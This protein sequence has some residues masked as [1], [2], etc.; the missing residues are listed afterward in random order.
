MSMHTSR[1]GAQLPYRPLAGVVPCP[2]GWLVAGAKLQGIT[3]S[4]EAPQVFRTLLDILDYKPAYQII[5]LAAPIGLLDE[6]VAGGRHCDRDARRLIGWPR[7]GAI[8][9]PPA[10]SVLREL[11]EGVDVSLSAVGRRLVA[12]FAEVDE[13]IQP[14]WQRTVFEV[15]PELSFFQ[16]NE[17]Q[18]LRYSKHR[19][20]GVD[21]RTA[22]L[23]ARL[24]GVE[25]ILVTRV[26]GAK[27]A[28]HVD[29]AVCLWTARRIAARAVSR[30]PETPEWDSAG[31]RMEIV[32]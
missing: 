22:L 21:E 10:R 9:S 3:L 15:H 4:P 28:H 20:A 18:P 16:L 11:A 31:L 2:G 5:S 24:P 12:R 14:Y 27:P 29:S 25:R 13:D 7:N 19:Q 26:K 1:R 6:P 17:D 32:R 23:K 8:V 30:L